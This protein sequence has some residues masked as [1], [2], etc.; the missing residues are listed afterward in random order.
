VVK[1]IWPWVKSTFP[2][3]KSE[4]I[5]DIVKKTGSALGTIKFIDHW[6]RHGTAQTDASY[7]TFNRREQAVRLLDYTHKQKNYMWKVGNGSANEPYHKT[8]RA[9]RFVEM[10][11]ATQQYKEVVID[12]VIQ[13]LEASSTINASKHVWRDQGDHRLILAN[14]GVICKVLFAKTEYTNLAEV[15]V[16]QPFLEI[17][18]EGLQRKTIGVE[19]DDVEY[20]TSKDIQWIL[21][22]KWPI[23]RGHID[24][25]WKADCPED[26]I[27]T[28]ENANFRDKGPGGKE[29]RE[30]CIDALTDLPFMKC[31]S[32]A[33]CPPR[34]RQLKGQAAKE[35]SRPRNISSKKR[36]FRNMA[37]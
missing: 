35:R 15:F 12:S 10:P 17:V 20:S 34:C 4:N 32:L 9:I 18:R 27:P 5:T 31:P 23:D 16:A 14:G 24:F 21:F 22:G 30:M 6:N 19:L 7:V 3:E 28:E 2:G 13:V 26:A 25:P 1:V 11:S 33:R 36:N 37:Y 29:K 8:D